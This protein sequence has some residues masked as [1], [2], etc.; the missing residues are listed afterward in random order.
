V[1]NLYWLDQS[2]GENFPYRDQA[3]YLSQLHH[4][5][6]PVVNGFVLPGDVLWQYLE[7]LGESE[8]L[9]ADLHDSDL[10][11][12]VHQPRQLRDVAQRLRRRILQGSPPTFWLEALTE[13]LQKISTPL[14]MLQPFLQH[15]RL[16]APAEILE[17]VVCPAQ[18]EA[19]M[20][21][22]KQVWGQL[23]RA[24]HLFCWR[25]TG[26]KLSQVNLAVLVQPLGEAIASGTVVAQ[27]EQLSIESTWGFPLAIDRGEVLPDRYT[28][29]PQ[30]GIILKQ[31]LGSKNRGY[32]LNLPSR[33]SSPLECLTPYLLSPSQ[34]QSYSLT[35]EDLAL[36][37]QICKQLQKMIMPHFGLTWQISPSGHSHLPHLAII[38][39]TPQV[40]QGRVLNSL[41]PLRGM[42]VAQGEA[43]GVAQVMVAGVAFSAGQRGDHDHGKVAE[44]E[45][46]ESLPLT[47][48]STQPLSLSGK[49]LV[50]EIVLPEWLPF[51]RQAAGIITEQGGMT[52]HGAIIARELGIPA[53]VGVAAATQLIQTGEDLTLDGDQGI[54]YRQSG[55][56]L[57]RLPQKLVPLAENL[58]PPDIPS[59]RK[60]TWG[61]LINGTK[62]M[63][64]LSQTQKV[65][66][67]AQLPID[68]VGLLRSELILS[69][70]LHNHNLDSFQ[71]INRLGLIANQTNQLPLVA[72]QV[73]KNLAEQIMEFTAA[74]APRPVFYRSADWRSAEFP[75]LYTQEPPE[76]NPVLGRR[77]TLRYTL[78]PQLFDWELAA[79]REV[80]QRGYG[81]ISLLLPFVRTVEEFKFCQQRVQ[82]LGLSDQPHF[83]LWIMA[84]V[85]SVVFLL[86]DYVKAG[87]QGISIGSND[88]TQLILGIDRDRGGADLLNAIHPAM[89]AVMQQLV[90]TA[91]KLNIPCSICGQAPVN[92]PELVEQLVLW[93]IT[94]ISVDVPALEQVQRS[95]NQA[96]QKLLL[97][98]ARDL[99]L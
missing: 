52:S 50:A 87:V 22:L 32:H 83:Q 76:A 67:T 69:E 25:Q 30:T 44:T 3:F 10:H 62:L 24:H 46:T 20:A 18:S 89:L 19:V 92:Y 9:L 74:F 96:E 61:N 47:Q 11:L 26:L 93:G 53:V 27:P 8:V 55:Q 29:H 6:Y 17:T 80:Q 95:I 85:P 86:E 65:V 35:K 16:P 39:F 63:V 40:S 99:N 51:L 4:H 91:R 23:F 13:Q 31:Q 59:A 34:Q 48:I 5:G 64:N 49:I 38:N 97:N 88:L 68:G 70:I 98:L 78:D 33:E 73:I 72:Q 57:E 81:N 12:D 36:L 66:T 2:L 56:V 71:E 21:G 43:R 14:V 37:S 15:E 41:A 90:T 58:L 75:T 42:G 54:V 45:S 60:D 28:I 1:D 82:A 94:S 84:E 77:G 7:V 79:L